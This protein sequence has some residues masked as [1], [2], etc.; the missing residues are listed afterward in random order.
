MNCY[1]GNKKNFER[2]CE[3][4]IEGKLLAKTPEELMRSRYSAYATS[5]AKYIYQTYANKSRKN[6]SFNEIKDWAEQTQ[7]IKLKIICTNKD[8][9]SNYSSTNDQNILPFVE[10]CAFYIHDKTFFQMREKSRFTF[11]SNQWRYLDGDITEHTEI[12]PPKRNEPCFCQSNIKFKNCCA[13]KL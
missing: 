13:K 9:E 8:K 11:E 2:C 3:L 10:F 12:T 6:Q 7:W 5:N 1:C 4:F